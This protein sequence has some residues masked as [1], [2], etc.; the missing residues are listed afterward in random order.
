LLA[1]MLD[2]QGKLVPVEALEECDLF[3]R[4]DGEMAII[5]GEDR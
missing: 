2:L 4:S 3:M 1:L 5:I